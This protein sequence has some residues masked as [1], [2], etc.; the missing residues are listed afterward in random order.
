MRDLFTAGTPQTI[1]DVLHS[2]DER[3]WQQQQ[4]LNQFPQG[5]VVALKM[6]VPGPIKTNAQLQDLFA[7]GKQQLEAKFQDVTQL[8]APV[9]TTTNAGTEVFYVFAEAGLAAKRRA[10]AFEDQEP[11][12]RLFDADVLMRDHQHYSRSELGDSVRRCF[13]CERPAKECGRNRT[14]SVA[15]LQ[16]YFNRIAT[17][18]LGDD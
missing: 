15:E 14:H 7:V 3:V 16:A 1:A 2:K 6:N 9:V 5:T 18:V 4:L 10:I 11:V 12:G 17:E 8:Q 13:L